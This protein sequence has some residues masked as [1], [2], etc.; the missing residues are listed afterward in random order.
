MANIAFR[1]GTLANLPASRNADTLYFVTDTGE[2]FLGE[3]SFTRAVR[4]GLTSLPT[5]FAVGVLYVLNNGEGWSHNGIAWGRIFQA[6]D[7]DEKD[8]VELIDSENPSH[9]NIPTEQAVV[10]FVEIAITE[11]LTELGIAHNLTWNNTAHT[12]TIPMVG[13]AEPLVIN[14]GALVTGA[15]VDGFY[16]SATQE[17]VLV[18][19]DNSEIRIP[20][21]DLIKAYVSGSEAN[22]TVQVTIVYDATEGE[23]RIRTTIRVAASTFLTIAA[24]GELAFN[25]T[26]LA[27]AI[28]AALAP[29][30][31]RLDAI[32]ARLTW[33]T[34]E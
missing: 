8:I 18:L 19:A 17:I 30:I 2:L 34:F 29:L 16:D 15:I 5:T 22:D 26:A 31:T 23:Y 25:E 21:G 7:F 12:L 9:D 28:T 20:A 13:R 6:S 4:T 11:E 33:G 32:D 3:N 14:I 27:G 24:N 1:R 10:D